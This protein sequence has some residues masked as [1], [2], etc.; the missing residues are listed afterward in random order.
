[1]QWVLFDC[2][3]TLIDDFDASG[4]I[5][6]LE[7][8]A[9]LPVAAGLFPSVSKFR[10]AYTAARAVNWWQSDSEVHFEVRLREVFIRQGRAGT[11]SAD[12]LVSEM[13]DLFAQTYPASVRLTPGVEAMLQ[14]WS[15]GAKLAVV[16]NFFMPEWPQKML[17]YHRLGDYFEFVIDSAALGAKKPESE[18][19]QAALQR[20]G[21]DPAEVLF[22]GDDYQRDVVAPRTHGMQARHV[23]RHGV[24]PGI[25]PSPEDNAIKHWDAFRP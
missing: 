20:V 7:T 22:V 8:I 15:T 12:R 6:G 16:S 25:D 21:V 19:Y 9:H 14:A 3:N 24:R 11:A 5:D 1:M 10:S 4:S 2:F 17:E 23:C 13:L 18:I